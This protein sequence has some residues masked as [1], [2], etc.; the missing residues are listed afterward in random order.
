MANLQS[1]TEQRNSKVGVDKKKP[2][3]NLVRI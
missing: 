2:T 3:R 1:I